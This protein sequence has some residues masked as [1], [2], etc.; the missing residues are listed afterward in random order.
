MRPHNHLPE[1]SWFSRWITSKNFDWVVFLIITLI[2]LLA[3]L[4]FA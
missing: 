1:Q 4:S 3:F 2:I